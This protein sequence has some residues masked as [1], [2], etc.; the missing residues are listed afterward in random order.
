MKNY[1]KI[2]F[3]LLLSTALIL[4]AG[5]T[6]DDE[7]NDALVQEE[8]FFD[9]YMEANYPDAIA[10][11]SGLYYLE[12]EAGTGLSPAEDDWVLINHVS[13][14]LP[15]ERVYSSYIESVAIDNRFYD[16]QALY[17][18]YKTQNG[19]LNEGFTLGLSK[20]KEGGKA[21]FLFTSELGFGSSSSTNVSSYTSLK[22]EVELL[23][24]LGD[25]ETYEEEKLISY[26]SSIPGSD[27]IYDETS[28][29]FMYYVI[30][31]ANPDGSEIAADSIIKVKYKG[32]LI[33]GRV[34]DET[35]DEDY[36]TIT[37]GDDAT[38]I[39]G[40]KLGL[41]KFKEGEKGRLIIPW[42]LA[43]GPYG[44]TTDAGYVGIPPFETLV[45]D[46]EIMDV[47]GQ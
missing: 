38:V 17:G 35:E 34:F 41:L 31:E 19:I 10:E 14:T 30:D 46:I 33:D 18:P 23:E 13:Y 39:E 7:Q 37:M 16:A 43:Y 27:T 9:I 22:Y 2:Y 21:T 32:Y 25:I 26:G 28:E 47:I 11:E 15:D 20:M 6:E 45:F 5:C 24:V 1:N 36:L 12:E 3:L 40:W 4:F 42:E 44:N 8:R 29:A